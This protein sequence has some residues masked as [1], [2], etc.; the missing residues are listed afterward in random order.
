MNSRLSQALPVSCPHAAPDAE[1]VFL[2]RIRESCRF[3]LLEEVYTTPK[4]GLV[5]LHDSGAHKDMDCASFEA[6]EQAVTPYM[7]EMAK[8][9][10]RHEKELTALFPSIR[11]L[12]LECEQ[13]MLQATG[14]VNT[15]KGI[16]FSLGIIVSCLGYARRRL[17]P[18]SPQTLFSLCQ[19]A[20]RPW[21]LRDF[22]EMR[23]REPQ[24]HGERLF[25]QYG[26]RGIRGEAMDGFPSLAQAAL[27]AMERAAR[28][29]PDPNSAR[30]A[31]LL[32][33]MAQVDD[34]N[35]LSRSSPATLDYVKARS[36]AFIRR[37]PIIGPKAILELEEMN[38]DFI[39]RNIS[40]GGCADLLAIAVFF[41]RFAELEEG[42]L[43]CTKN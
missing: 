8:A 19:N 29:Q 21:L 30:L 22:E 7:A 12:G 18:V 43:L 39:R 17:G 16:I 35:I 2:D 20:V 32:T 24:T 1:S 37:H 34:T 31:V 41:K 36:Q 27:P 13:A 3:G 42:G 11:P 6:S 9:G 38:Q 33:L 23:Q 15:H 5:D 28:L 10:W 40:P 26:I 4:P 25:A 14:G